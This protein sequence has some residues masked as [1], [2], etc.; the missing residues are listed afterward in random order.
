MTRKTFYKKLREIVASGQYVLD[1]CD[2]SPQIRLRGPS[3]A[4]PSLLGPHGDLCPITAVAEAITGTRHR[5][6]R[7]EDAAK[8]IGLSSEDA[9]AIARSADGAVLRDGYSP[10]TRNALLRAVGAS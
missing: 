9:H 7:F 6:Y 4:P 10:N 8:S 2:Y 1:M 5:L 3:S